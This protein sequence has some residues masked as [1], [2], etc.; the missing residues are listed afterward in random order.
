MY[1]IKNSDEVKFNI[2]FNTFQVVLM[3]VKARRIV[4]GFISLTIIYNS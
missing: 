4:T 1:R 3:Q 2:L